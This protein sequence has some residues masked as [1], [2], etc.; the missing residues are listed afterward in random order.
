M[1]RVLIAIGATIAGLVALLTFKSHTVAPAL[2]AVPAASG[3]SASGSSAPG[4]S[5]PG[6][7]AS[8]GGSA[9]AGRGG[10]SGVPTRSSPAGGTTPG[11]SGRPAGPTVLTGHAF[12]TKFGPMQ[13][14]VTLVNRKIVKVTVLQHT[15]LGAY[16]G[17]IDARALPQLSQETLTAQSARIDA[18][19]GASYTSEG[20]IQSLQSALDQA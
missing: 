6:S 14:Q 12:H 16:S 10:S 2:G 8:G 19:S 13:V 11:S 3:A 1:L 17:Q 4:S 9:G 5:A 18:V 20:Y 15:D 7:S